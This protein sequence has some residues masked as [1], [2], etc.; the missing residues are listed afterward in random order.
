MHEEIY[1]WFYR[2]NK[3]ESKEYLSKQNN[4]STLTNLNIIF[5]I[6]LLRKKKELI[7]LY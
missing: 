1:P 5:I 7:R 2:E 4:S 6:L 3:I